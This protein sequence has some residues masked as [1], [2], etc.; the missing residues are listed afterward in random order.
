[1]IGIAALCVG[2][3]AAALAL[4]CRLGGDFDPLREPIA[5]G[6]LELVTVDDRYYVVE[7]GAAVTPEDLVLYTE[8][9]CP[10]SAKAKARERAA[11]GTN[12][13]P[14]A[15]CSGAVMH[16]FPSTK[17]VSFTLRAPSA[18]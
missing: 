17:E 16:R 7:K 9:V 13:E 5:G 8:F 6:S 10:E 4:G 1:M 3:G 14:Q 15:I 18:S 12:D 11:A 2:L